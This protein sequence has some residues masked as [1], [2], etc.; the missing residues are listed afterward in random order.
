MIVD[1]PKFWQQLATDSQIYERCVH[2][3]SLFRTPF[4][5]Y[6]ES[7][8]LLHN[9]YSSVLKYLKG[10][11]RVYVEGGTSYAHSKLFYQNPSLLKES[12][13]QY[14]RKIFSIQKADI[15]TDQLERFH[16][17]IAQRTARFAELITQKLG[18]LYFTCTL[19]L[20]TEDYGE[21]PFGIHLTLLPSKIKPIS[22]LSKSN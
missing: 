19:T 3:S 2:Y 17:E 12:I 10:N 7:I 16:D 13:E 11:T 22:S 21:T 14:H 1:I 18:F 9:W 8:E 15:F 6:T 5:I 20:L 4:C